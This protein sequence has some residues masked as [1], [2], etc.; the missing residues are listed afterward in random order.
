MAAISHPEF[1]SR[2]DFDFFWISIWRPEPKKPEPK[3]MPLTASSLSHT[4]ARAIEARTKEDATNRPAEPTRRQETIRGQSQYYSLKGKEARAIVAQAF[5]VPWKTFPQTFPEREGTLKTG[6]KCRHFSAG[7]A[8]FFSLQG[9]LQQFI[10]R[11]WRRL[12]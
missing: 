8:G 7:G 11:K 10:E 2:F 6:A 12:C 1:K 4:E 3:K 5:K 9:V